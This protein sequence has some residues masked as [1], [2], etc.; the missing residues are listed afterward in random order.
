MQ[1][2]KVNPGVFAYTWYCGVVEPWTVCGQARIPPISI[3]VSYLDEYERRK[4][5]EPVPIAA[6]LSQ[7]KTLNGG[8]EAQFAVTTVIFVNA[9]AAASAGMLSLCAG[10]KLSNPVLAT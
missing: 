10:V 9:P 8:V 5:H 2:V 7:V 3:S 6:E 1:L 4:V